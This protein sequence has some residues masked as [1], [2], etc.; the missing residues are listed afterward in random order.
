MSQGKGHWPFW[1][2]L[3]NF[4]QDN[5][6]V[7]GRSPT[8]LSPT[9]KIMVMLVVGVCLCIVLLLR[10]GA[11]IPALKGLFLLNKLQRRL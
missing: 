10:Q 7:D 1:V 4:Y 8:L 6:E 9:G 2:C 11:G 3:R 5:G